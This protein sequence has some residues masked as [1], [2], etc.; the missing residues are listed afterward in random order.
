MKTMEQGSTPGPFDPQAFVETQEWI[1]AKTMPTIPHFYVVRGR[2]GC[3]EEDWDA[4]ATY[5]RE[6][7]YRAQWTAPNGKLM[8]NTYLELGKWK[9][10]VILPVINRERIENSTTVRLQEDDEK[11]E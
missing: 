8:I 10:W 9:Y 4:M 11:G 2:K 1:F 7:G 3:A 5:I 6:H